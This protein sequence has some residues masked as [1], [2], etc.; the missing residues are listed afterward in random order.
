M[1]FEGLDNL[2]KENGTT[3]CFH[4]EM[5]FG[6][7]EGALEYV[8]KRIAELKNLKEDFDKFS[9]ENKDE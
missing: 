1:E 5:H 9:K 8:N 3:K 4:R 7:A 6:T 2:I